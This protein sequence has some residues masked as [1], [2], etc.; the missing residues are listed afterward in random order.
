VRAPFRVEG[1]VIVTILIATLTAACTETASGPTQTYLP[2]TALIVP[3]SVT[4]SP[5]PR[6]TPRRTIKVPASIDA[7]GRTDVSQAL[8]AFVDSVPDHSV[9]RFP[10][11]ASYRL[12]GDGIVLD[13]RQDLVFIGHDVQ[14]SGAG[15]DVLDSL[16]IIGA[17]RPSSAIRIEGLTL[18]GDNAAAGTPDTFLAGCE[19]Q[20]GVAVY[21]S[22]DVEISDVTVRSVRGDCLYVGGRGD[23]FIWS[24]D[25]TFR[26][27]VCSGPGR[28]GV[29]VVAG[30]RSASP[31][32]TSSPTTPSRVRLTSVSPT[33]PSEP[34]ASPATG[35]PR[36]CSRPTG[37]PTRS[38]V[39][40]SPRAI[41][42]PGSLCP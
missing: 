33:T 11:N 21:G 40:S 13:G 24:S 2:A 37:P 18:I 32:S 28:M 41:A 34:S 9:V 22:S 39:A 4:P 25:V 8:Q 42:C 5:S 14:L 7:T 3:A 10:T 27:S 36:G 31:R 26:D 23:P 6:P 35:I 16:F 19:Y 17:R 1:G 12:D 38:C 29:A 30:Q 15:C 20:M